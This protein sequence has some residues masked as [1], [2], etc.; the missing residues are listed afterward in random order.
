MHTLVLKRK[1]LEREP[2]IAISLYKAFVQAKEVNYKHL[3]DTNTLAVSLPWL[4]DQNE[5]SRRIFRPEAW[6]YSMEVG[7]PTLE[8]LVQSLD[9]QGL[10]RRRMKIEELFAPNISPE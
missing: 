6:I 5:R 8:A 2:W 1:F 9:E 10:S 3:Y 4:V 7:R